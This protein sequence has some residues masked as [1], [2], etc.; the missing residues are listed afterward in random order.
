VV[1]V[2]DSI[3]WIGL[4]KNF[5]N[6]I[7]MLFQTKIGIRCRPFAYD[8]HHVA[9]FVSSTEV[10]STTGNDFD[11]SAFLIARCLE[12]PMQDCI[13]NTRSTFAP[14]QCITELLPCKE[15]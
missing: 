7:P 2:L 1:F 15:H 10:L 8:C 13:L 6:G 5:R 11:G 3:N 12:N 4:S 14:N 9:F